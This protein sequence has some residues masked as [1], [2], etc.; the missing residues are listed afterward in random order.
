MMKNAE[1]HEASAKSPDRREV[2]AP[3]QSIPAEDPEAEERRLEHERREPLDRERRAEDVTDVLRVHGPVHP[4]LELLHEPGRDADREVDEHQR[5]EEARQPQPSV[6]ASAVPEG[7]HDCDERR[8][9]ERQRDE[10][11][12]VQRRR[13]EL[14]PREVDRRDGECAQ[15]RPS[16]AAAID[17]ARRSGRPPLAT[18][19]QANCPSAHSAPLSVR[20]HTECLA[21]TAGSV[22]G[23]CA[24]IRAMRRV[25]ELLLHQIDT[26]SRQRTRPGPDTRGLIGSLGESR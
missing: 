17:L 16:L 1:S 2:D 22:P 4:E 26:G 8:E 5:A 9:P 20:R 12:V 24:P 21:A 6:V 3:R 15:G 25:R 7:L 18:T 13:R 10:Q 11:E 23:D 19:T 14:E